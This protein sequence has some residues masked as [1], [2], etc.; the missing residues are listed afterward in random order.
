MLY[1]T[2]NIIQNQSEIQTYN[3][4]LVVSIPS[5]GSNCQRLIDYVSCTLRIDTNAQSLFRFLRQEKI[6][7]DR[8]TMFITCCDYVTD[9]RRFDGSGGCNCNLQTDYVW[10]RYVSSMLQEIGT[11]SDR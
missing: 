1:F 3:W 6:I 4:Y 11:I 5:A 8:E 10:S 9:V 7:S 2:L